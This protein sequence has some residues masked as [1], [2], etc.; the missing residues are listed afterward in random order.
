[1]LPAVTCH[2]P[3]HR[4]FS[5]LAPSGPTQLCKHT[6]IH[7]LSMGAANGSVFFLLEEPACGEHAA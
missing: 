2:Q 7:K 1:M 6:F 3:A 5:V 4:L